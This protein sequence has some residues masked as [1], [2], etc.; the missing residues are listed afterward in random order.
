MEF[1]L[2]GTS[3]VKQFKNPLAL[4]WDVGTEREASFLS[5]YTHRKFRRISRKFDIE[6]KVQK[7][8]LDLYGGDVFHY[9]FHIKIGIFGPNL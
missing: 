2:L 5:F 4:G 6:L 9:I 1:I 8:I 3:R 7:Y